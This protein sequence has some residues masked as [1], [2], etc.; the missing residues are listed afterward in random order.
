MVVCCAL[1]V[2]SA[3]TILSCIESNFVFCVNQDQVRRA[4]LDNKG[5]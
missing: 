1:V 3:N 4:H 5:D 2:N